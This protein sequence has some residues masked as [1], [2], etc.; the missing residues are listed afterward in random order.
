MWRTRYSI[1][2]PWK[3]QNDLAEVHQLRIQMK[4][5]ARQLFSAL[6]RSLHDRAVVVTRSAIQTGDSHQ[7]V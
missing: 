1:G 6:G 4:A 3:L 2:R 5:I 7:R